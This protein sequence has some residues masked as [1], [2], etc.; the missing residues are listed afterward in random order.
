MQAV[1]MYPEGQ[2]A[3]QPDMPKSI[4]L[5][6][7]SHAINVAFNAAGPDSTADIVIGWLRALRSSC[8]RVV[9]C[10]DSKPYWRTK[11]FEGY[12]A[13]RKQEPELA[14][15]WDRVLDQVIGEG[16]AVARADGEEADDVM[17][18]LA[19]IYVEDYACEDVR[20]V[21]ADKDISQCLNNHVRWFY[22]QMGSGEFEI[23]DADWC[24]RHWGGVDWANEKQIKEGPAPEEIARVL[25]IMGDTSD[26]IPG[27]KG[28]GIKGALWLV[29]TF[30]TPAKMAEGLVAEQQVARNKGKELSAFWRNFAAG[31]AELPKWIK[32]TTVND[33]VQLDK[34]PMKYLE[35]IEPRQLVAEDAQNDAD[36][37]GFLQE[38]EVDWEFIAEQTAAKEREELAKALPVDPAPKHDPKGG[39]GPGT[40]PP[41][42]AASPAATGAGH[43]PS[44]MIVGKDPKADEAL[45]ELAAK[46]PPSAPAGSSGSTSASTTSAPASTTQPPA[47]TTSTAPSP[48]PAKPPAFQAAPSVGA[49]AAAS[50]SAPSAATPQ[51][52]APDVL[53]LAVEIARHAEQGRAAAQVVPPTQGPPKPRRDAEG[54][55]EPPIAAITPYAAPCWELS[56]QP[57]SAGH[58]FAIAKRLH[59][60]RLY[61]K[62]FQTAEQIGVII[63]R[64]R[65]LGLGMTTALD[66]FHMIEGVPHAASQLISALA[67]QD[68]EHDYAM[69][70]ELDDVHCIVEIKHKRQPKPVLWKYHIDQAHKLGLT[71]PSK[72]TGR[73]S[74]WV[75]RPQTMLAKTAKVIGHRFMF[76]GRTLGLHALETNV[77][78]LDLVQD[79][80]S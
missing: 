45:R 75:L 58:A 63:L 20:L 60:S 43:D 22:P 18:S 39:G 2:S 67:E 71:A 19:R 26:K 70:L 53:Q 65:E 73:D 59:N 17:A 56:T 1:N 13:G 7:F 52:D 74:Q 16:F 11:V 51:D 41:M 79:D 35:R 9:L 54:F 37:S 23:R 31:M 62:K 38:D 40:Q 49:A 46:L 6:D 80:G 10:L 14:N 36:E 15:I 76:P 69:L 33:D 57:A 32:L 78:G 48:Q 55:E 42:A 47:A 66:A 61:M 27:I 28:I 8:D 64:G 68:K 5:F 44:K 30:G 4:A 77:E 24:K 34:H 50:A 21:T 25:S 3:A 72:R 12:K 29:R